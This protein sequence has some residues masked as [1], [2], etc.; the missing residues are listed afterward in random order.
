MGDFEA[1]VQRVAAA[2]N[3]YFLNSF[4]RIFHEG[5][6]L[7]FHKLTKSGDGGDV[8]QLLRR[9]G[10]AAMRCSPAMF[11]EYEDVLKRPTQ[12][13]ASGL[14]VSD[15]DVILNDLAG[16]I[17]PVSTHYQCQCQSNAGLVDMRRRGPAEFSPS[18]STM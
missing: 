2:F 6:S 17:E 1:H 13:A 9:G 16:S 12:R 4:L 10:G 8:I 14:L 18:P 5:Y 3:C 15:M 7:F 11:L